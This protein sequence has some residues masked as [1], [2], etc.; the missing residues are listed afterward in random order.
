MSLDF[1]YRETPEQAFYK[2][3]KDV[4]VGN[5]VQMIENLELECVNQWNET[6]PE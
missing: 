3:L 6:I 5:Y 4:F 2:R 1:D